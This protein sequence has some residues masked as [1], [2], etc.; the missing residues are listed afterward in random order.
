MSYFNPSL[1]FMLIVVPMC[2]HSLRLR[3]SFNPSPG[4]MPIVA[5]L[6]LANAARYREKF[7]S[8]TW[9]Y[10]Y[11]SACISLKAKPA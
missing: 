2:G 7:Q 1:G 11:C 3:S 5:G 10:A 4:F 8:L 9:V 6:A